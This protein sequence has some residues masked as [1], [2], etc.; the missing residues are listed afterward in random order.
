MNG[1]FDAWSPWVTRALSTLLT[2][3]VAWA[4]GRV[5][6]NV[7]ARIITRWADRTR[8]TWDDVLA[9]TLRR[10]LPLWS[11]LVGAWLAAG[12]WPLPP[13]GE[14]LVARGIFVVAA[15]SITL[16]AAAVASELVAA[17]G[18]A[19]IPTVQVTS[20]TQSIA[21][22]L[23]GMFGLLIV[24]NGI[25]VSIAPM[26]TALGV[27]GLAVALA[28]QEPLANFFAG[29]FVTLAGQVRVGDYVQLD[30]GIEGYITDFSWRSTRIRQLSNNLVLV[31]NAKL[32]QAIVTNY[33]RP[34]RDLA[35][36]MPVGV[37]YAS[38][39]TKVERVTCDVGRDVMQTVSG[40]VPDFE[41]FIRYHTFGESSIDFT[42]I[43]RAQEFTD[44]Y[45]VK[46]EFVKRLHTRFEREGIVGPV[47]DPNAGEPR[48]GRHAAGGVFG[49]VSTAR[50]AHRPTTFDRQ[51]GHHTEEQ[52]NVECSPGPGHRAIRRRCGVRRRD[53][54]PCHSGIDDSSRLELSIAI[55]MVAGC[56]R[57]RVARRGSGR[58]HVG[59][60]DDVG[61][62]RLYRRVHH[63]SRVGPRG[64]GSGQ[65]PRARLRLGR[66]DS[67][68][69][70]SSLAPVWVPRRRL[71]S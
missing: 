44:Q 38:D 60:D 32:S 70:R 58:W 13:N 30:S 15:T 68:D 35:V 26:L 49:A 47:S 24:L 64:V 50:S 41:P 53:C 55:R 67:G 17:Y 6:G 54:R 10:R 22:A 59:R 34:S 62:R 3:V 5:L 46:H 9:A 28:L 57:H 51:G 20:L 43:L 16:A 37:D 2:L 8:A 31:P 36:L 29:L 65:R 4:V 39:L 11:M 23:V 48:A 69:A 33:Y 71:D 45:L 21:W 66:A 1:G 52:A 18:A 14:L 56:H 27:G 25:G 19:V 42:V 40:G 7:A 63:G 61:V 12:Y